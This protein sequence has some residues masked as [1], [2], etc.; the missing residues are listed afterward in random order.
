MN[1]L[2]PAFSLNTSTRSHLRHHLLIIAFAALSLG[3]VHAAPPPNDN[4]ANAILLTADSVSDTS[5]NT[6]ATNEA[7]DPP[8]AGYR[9]VWW[10]YRPSATGR[11]TV[12]TT[13]SAAFQKD[14]GV[15][16][17]NNLSSLRSVVYSVTNQAVIT[18]TFPVTANA[19]YRISVGSHFS[20][21]GTGYAGNV[22]LGLSL[23]TQADVSSVNVPF[24]ATMANDAFAQR[25]A[26]TG[27]TVGAIGYNVSAT[28]EAAASEPAS[29]GYGT[30]WWSYR[31]SANGRL[32]IS[33]TGS[34]IFNRDVAVYLGG[35]LA[36]LRVVSHRTESGGDS[37]TIPVT[38]NTDYQISVGSNNSNTGSG[39]RGS[40]VL[41]LLLDTQAD[42]AGLNLPVPAAAVNDNFANRV[43]LPGS[44]VSA[45]GYNTKAIR[46]PGEPANTKE[47]TI[48]WSWTAPAAGQTIVD[49]AYSD[50]IS[51]WVSIWRGG[52]ISAL[53]QVAI[54][55]QANEPQFTFNATAGETYHIAVGNYYSGADGG[56]IVLTIIGAAGNAGSAVPNVTLDR[57]I[58]LRWF[59]TSGLRYQVQKSFDLQSWTNVGALIIGNG[60]FKDFFEA[61][62]TDSAYY[63]LFLQN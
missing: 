48:W 32:T 31:P 24:S 58:H 54:S 33:T 45:I 40:I 25:V 19:D 42:V 12:T 10:T 30:L 39:Y 14:L 51:K 36:I 9:T 56:S 13:N 5:N 20:N 8:Q 15:Y 43:V 37:I 35:S 46:E 1:T 2:A 49:L 7:G 18:F 11:L 61:A 16:L 63:R 3:S 53:Q 34:D 29:S 55:T 22:V 60:T 26:L 62:T 52:T 41:S 17:G 21:T 6:E 57:A 27:T 23:D 28:N 50:A 47:R 59:A 38:A 44:T 4:F